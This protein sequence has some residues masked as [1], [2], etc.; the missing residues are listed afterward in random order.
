MTAQISLINELEEALS[1]GSAERRTKTLRRVTDLF[2]FGS[3][4]FSADHIA[5]F[6]GVFNHLIADVER[7]ARVELAARLA[8]I[9]KAPPKVM[10]TLAFDDAIE[11]AAP[12]LAQSE[13]LDNVALVETAN[14][15]SQRHLLAITERKVLAEVVTD[16]LVER[17]NREVALKVAR[18]AGARL[19]E[20]GYIRLVKRADRDDELARSVGARS[21]IPRHHFLKLLSTASKAVR[22]ALEAAHPEHAGEVRRV[23]ADVASSIQSKAAATSRN[24]VA[25]LALVESMHATGRLGEGDVVAF[26]CD[27]KF[28]ET[29]AAL[30]TLA[31]LPVDVIERAIVQDRQETILIVV[32]AIGLSWAA[33]KAVLLLRAGKGA[34]SEHMLR[35]SLEIFNRLKRETAQQVVEFQ[36]KRQAAMPSAADEAIGGDPI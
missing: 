35:Q 25:A 18:N 12:V 14:T 11:V 15:K 22:L 16:V 5:V 17:G 31:H 30:A 36:Q 9:P 2:A 33:A 29:A 10:R 7:S 4:H 34:M 28:E 6:E 3:S 21:E 32:K 27:G 1:Q 23:V 8:A 24:Y 26:A 13:A 20:T 19:S